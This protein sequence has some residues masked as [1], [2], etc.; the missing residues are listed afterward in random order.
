LSFGLKEQLVFSG[1]VEEI[2]VVLDVEATKDG[3]RLKIGASGILKDGAIGESIAVSG[4]CLTVTEFTEDWF[5]VEAINETLRRTKCGDLKVG[6]RVNLE[7]ALRVSDRLG[8]H[9]VTGH[10]D[11]IATVKSIDVDGFSWDIVF[12]LDGKWAPYFVEKGS[13]CVDGVS[14]TVA[15]IKEE[16][17]Q[18]EDKFWFRVALIPHT[19]SVTTLGDLVCGATVNIETDIIARYVARLTAANSFENH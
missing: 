19:L 4:T 10:V 18:G 15:S 14:L 12:E 8:G 17:C 9:I 11:T 5:T 3:Q 7:K 16:R 2:G 1:I 13:V 6:S